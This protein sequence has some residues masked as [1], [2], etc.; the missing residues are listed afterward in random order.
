[1]IALSGYLSTPT[2]FARER[3]FVPFLSWLAN[4]EHPRIRDFNSIVLFRFLLQKELY[5]NAVASLDAFD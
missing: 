1:M 2:F 3:R 4:H 5:L